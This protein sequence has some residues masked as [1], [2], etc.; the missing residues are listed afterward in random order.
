MIDLFGEEVE[1]P[2]RKS[3]LSKY[4]LFKMANNYRE[5]DDDRRK[6]GFCVFHRSCR[7]HDKIYHK[8][9]LIGD[10]NSSATDIRV[11]HVCDKFEYGGNKEPE[12]L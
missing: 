11:G 9:E 7:Y 2:R 3:R 10:S 8:C 6:C 5:S 4:Q 12:L 1:A